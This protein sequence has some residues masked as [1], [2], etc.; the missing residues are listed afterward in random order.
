[1]LRDRSQQ[2]KM[3]EKFRVN[4]KLQKNY[5]IL[6]TIYDRKIL[7]AFSELAYKNYTDTLKNFVKFVT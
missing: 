2:F 4:E 7:I 3:H 5:S 6:K 1:M